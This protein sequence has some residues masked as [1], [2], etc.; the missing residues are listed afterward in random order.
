MIPS[1]NNA[2]DNNSS[3]SVRVRE[4]LDADAD[5]TTTGESSS[6][7]VSDRAFNDF[8]IQRSKG[9][10]NFDHLHTPYYIPHM[11]EVGSNTIPEGIVLKIK[12]SLKRATLERRVNYFV[13]FTISVDTMLLAFESHDPA[14][15]SPYWVLVLSWICLFIYFLEIGFRLYLSSPTMAF[16]RERFYVFDLLI[17]ILCTVMQV[18]SV[19]EGLATII[20]AIR[21]TRLLRMIRMLRML[22]ACIRLMEIWHNYNMSKMNSL[23]HQESILNMRL[24][25]NIGDFKLRKALAKWDYFKTISEE[26]EGITVKG[27]RKELGVQDLFTIAKLLKEE[28]DFELFN[29]EE[30]CVEWLILLLIWGSF[31]V[32]LS[33]AFVYL[34]AENYDLVVEE[35]LELKKL[36]DSSLP[37]RDHMPDLLNTLVSCEDN[38]SR[39]TYTLFESIYKEYNSTS[40]TLWNELASFETPY[41]FMNPW[42]FQGSTFFTV[43]IVTTIGYGTFTPLTETGKLVVIFCSLPAI[44]L[45]IVF[46]QKNM[47]L[48]QKGFCRTKYDSLGLRIFF[49]IIFLLSFIIFGGLIMRNSEGWTMWDAIYFCWVSF[50]TIGFGDYAP[51]AGKNWNVVFLSL[52]VVGWNIVIFVITVIERA[53]AEW[54]E[55]Q[56][57]NEQ[58]PQ[59]KRK[60]ANLDRQR[61]LSVG[62]AQ[63]E[64]TPTSN[65]KASSNSN[66]KASSKIEEL[67]SQIKKCEDQLSYLKMERKLLSFTEGSLCES[68][69][70]ENGETLGDAMTSKPDIINR[71]S[72]YD[73]QRGSSSMS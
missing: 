57:W 31:I 41:T 48:L 15:P 11:Q 28:E 70:P 46:G 62:F 6:K 47:E 22:R 69:S 9:P 19:M 25:L 38:S 20:R 40:G 26:G 43:S 14:V 52:V 63:V 4:L 49:S 34:E 73:Q 5:V 13:L 51:V 35:N 42:T 45:T 8:V 18:A 56:W 53:T 12:Q 68:S 17:V 61:S 66:V 54:K 59:P 67:D 10:E 55:M 16:F 1:H 7:E 37:V 2:T 71:N 33:W 21:L 60:S 64:Q 23:S 58:E 32:G 36:V 30:F 27:N 24:R 29:F 39:N 72:D 44:Y 65:V 3:S 50:S